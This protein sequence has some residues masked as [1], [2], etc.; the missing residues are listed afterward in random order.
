MHF[1]SKVNGKVE[2][3]HFVENKSKGWLRPSRVTD[4]KKA[5][6]NGE[7]WFPSVT[8][9]LN[10]LDKP[11]LVNWKVDK[12]LEQVHFLI[13][14]NEDMRSDDFEGF[15]KM[16]IAKTSEALESAPKAGTAIHE[17][18]ENYVKKGLIPTDSMEA[19]I[20]ENVRQAILEATGED[21]LEGE[22]PF[23]T[24]S[25]FVNEE[26]GFAGCA[27]L[28]SD[29]WCIDYKSKQEKAKFKPGKMA[30]NDHTRQL[31]AYGDSLCDKDFR[32]ANVFVC[33]EDGSVD[34]HEHNKEALDKGYDDF[35]DCLSIYKRNTY[36]Q[37]EG[38]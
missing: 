25:Y 3:K 17:V 14:S 31:G 33:L 13:N 18:L 32:A 36:N 4:A 24:E 28:V 1:Y 7:V 35:K 37:I 2:P 6:K 38:K 16:I 27:D 10:M 26:V 29:T 12:H 8:S 30:F 5:L 23:I 9:I 34:F 19:L 21:I 15:K 22:H 20:C 11:A